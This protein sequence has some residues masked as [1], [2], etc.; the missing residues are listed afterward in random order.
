MH[1]STLEVLY[2]D[3]EK[4]KRHTCT[5]LQDVLDHQLLWFGVFH[6]GVRYHFA[7]LGEHDRGSDVEPVQVK[8]VVQVVNHPRHDRR[9][10]NN[11]IALLRLSS[12]VQLTSYITPVCLVSPSFSVLSQT[13]CVTTGWG[14]TEH[15]PTPPILQQTTLPIVSTTQC[16]QHFGENKITISM[17]CAGGSGSS[18]CMGDSGGPLVCQSRGVCYQAGIVSWG[19]SDCNVRS[20]AVYSHFTFLRQWID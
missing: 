11:D 6:T 16:K 12:A 10:F 20:P 3:R 19:K 1:R 8:R 4:H 13:Y 9:T 17:I 18:S 5:R 7:V 14:R 2:K 15:Y